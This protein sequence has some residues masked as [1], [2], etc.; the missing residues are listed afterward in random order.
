MNQHF[1]CQF[2][3]AAKN[4]QKDVKIAYSK[5]FF[6]TAYIKNLPFLRIVS[7]YEVDLL[8]YFYIKVGNL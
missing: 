2:I 6:M 8:S 7:C 5:R 4:R 1:L 3:N